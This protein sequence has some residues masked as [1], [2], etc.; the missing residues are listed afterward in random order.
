M[1]TTSWDSV[2]GEVELDVPLLLAVF[3]L[4]PA[5]GFVYADA[6]G[7]DGDADGL[8]CLLEAAVRVDG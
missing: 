7:V 2:D 4:Y 3:P 8:T 5:S 1:A 6:G